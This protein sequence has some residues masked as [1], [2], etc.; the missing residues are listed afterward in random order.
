MGLFFLFLLV[1]PV[2]LCIGFDI[3]QRFAVEFYLVVVYIC[4]FCLKWVYRDFTL[5]FCL[6]MGVTGN[7]L[8]I[9]DLIGLLLA[10]TGMVN[11]GCPSLDIC[12]VE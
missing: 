6:G 10:N 1:V 4:V 2:F 5:K 11:I 9:M 7:P 8:S 12:L 3:C